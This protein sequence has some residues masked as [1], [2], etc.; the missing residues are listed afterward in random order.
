MQMYVYGASPHKIWLQS[1]LGTERQV[2]P[3]VS[4]KYASA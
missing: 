3:T 1:L 4:N 2:L